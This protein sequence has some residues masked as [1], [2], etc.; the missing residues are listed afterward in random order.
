[1]D[2][3]GPYDTA[4]DQNTKAGAPTA[5]PDTEEIGKGRP[6]SEGWG[7]ADQVWTRGQD[8]LRFARA[9]KQSVGY[10]NAAE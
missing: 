10:P 5:F 3:N 6:E 8:G 7:S 2:V 4:H 9:A 1:M